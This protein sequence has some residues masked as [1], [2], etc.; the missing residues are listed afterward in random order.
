[1]G[2]AHVEFVPAVIYGRDGSADN[3]AED[4][5][6][7][8]SG[9]NGRV[10]MYHVK[11]SPAKKGEKEEDWGTI[12]ALPLSHPN[13]PGDGGDYSLR[14]TAEPFLGR[15]ASYREEEAVWKAAGPEWDGTWPTDHKYTPSIW[16]GVYVAQKIGG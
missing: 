15:F 6:T 5:Y 4:G 11:F 14:T 12:C 7:I 9:R 3:A 13:D 10:A 8:P 1:V 2:V 16:D